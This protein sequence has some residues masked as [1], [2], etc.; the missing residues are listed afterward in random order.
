MLLLG[1]SGQVGHELA[2]LFAGDCLLRPD[3]ADADLS[4]PKTLR[5]LVR[6]ME[7]SIILNAAAYTAVDRAEAEPELADLLN[8]HAPAVLA[9]EAERTGAL[10]VHYSTDYVFDG[11]K[12]LPWIET[13]A[14]EPLNQYGR[15]KLAGEQAIAA[16]CR[17]HLILR[18]SWVYGP[19]GHN[20]LKTMLRFGREREALRIVDDQWGAPTSSQALAEATCA[21]VELAGKDG[22]VESWAGVYHTTCAGAVSWAGFARAIF[23]GMS[24]WTSRE[25][26]RID[27]ITTAEYPTAA[28]RP[29]NS[30]LSNAKLTQRF[31]VQLPGWETALTS[32]LA[33]LGEHA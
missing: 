14:T 18:T 6:G 32:V 4:R 21:M 30:V 27:P 29:R 25:R 17:R 20:F 7:P 10:L 2:K 24:D 23:A 16:R 8:H 15:T 28:R 33:R 13:D 1:A 31:G 26:P 22:D 19:H 3:R 5:A 11:S 9:E 12:A